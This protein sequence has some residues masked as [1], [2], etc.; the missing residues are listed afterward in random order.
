MSLGGLKVAYYIV[1]QCKVFQLEGTSGRVQ[2]AICE[3]ERAG[4]F[5]ILN[6]SRLFLRRVVE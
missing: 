3:K 2:S 5:K 4:K 6:M 1:R